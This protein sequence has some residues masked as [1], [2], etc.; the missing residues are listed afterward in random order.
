MRYWRRTLYVI[1]VTEFFAMAGFSFVSPFMPYFVQEL[2]ITDVSQV[3]L[4]SGLAQ[5][6]MAVGLAVMAPVWG[7]LA[8]RFGRKA[9]VIRA[10]LAGAFIMTLMGFVTNVEQLVALRLLQGVF[11][12]TVAA[13]TTL[14]AGVVPRERSG[15]AMGSLQTAIYL[16]TALGP[17]V[18]GISGDHL[19]YRPSFWIT[20]ALL[21][22]SG[23][24]VTAFVQEDFKP[25]QTEKR[26]P[27]EGLQ[28]ARAFVFASGGTL[29]V[30][31]VARVLTRA[32]TLVPNAVMALFIQ[33]LAPGYGQIATL[34]GIVSGAT[35]VSA[36]IGSPAIGRWGDRFGHRK[37]LIASSASAALLYIP[38]AFAPNPLW[39]I[40]WQVAAGFAI[41]GT[42]STLTALLLHKSP[43]GREGA[44]FGLDA[45]MSGLANAVG[46]MAGATCAAVFGLPASF[47]LAA[48]V[49]GFGAV[50]VLWVRESTPGTLRETVPAATD[51]TR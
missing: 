14:V 13:A 21:F 20:G 7:V 41:G 27:R 15:A 35:A 1:A 39:L 51:P 19:G 38:Q 2:G 29:A 48:A 43:P 11:T 49:L 24:L 50:V 22:L 30:L 28:Q 26:S 37:L 12:G 31:L 8:D 46:P 33:A 34:T 40:I 4:W 16:G 47:L 25:V 42:I 5:S 6:A 44:V 18:G 36:A 23:V 32:G 45:S 10:T 3:A 9:M 17:L